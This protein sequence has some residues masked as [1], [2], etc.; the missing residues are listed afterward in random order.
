MPPPE[1]GVAGQQPEHQFAVLAEEKRAAGLQRVL[2]R[3]DT[4][5]VFDQLGD[6]AGDHGGEQ[7]LYHRG[8]RYLSKLEVLLAGHRPLLL[9][10]TVTDDNVAFIGDLT[11]M[12][13][14]RNGEIAIPHGQI[15]LFRS[16]ILVDKARC[17][18][19]SK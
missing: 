17:R 6:I 8:T 14:R 15:H 1:Q 12:D 4:F 16:R 3:G 9:S 11:N 5:G 7:G 19:G 18:P 10:S 2:K 13:V